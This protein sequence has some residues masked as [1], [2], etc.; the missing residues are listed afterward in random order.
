MRHVG[1]FKH[2]EKGMRERRWW[3]A[4]DCY[5]MCIDASVKRAPHLVADDRVDVLSKEVIIKLTACPVDNDS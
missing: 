5:N 1:R 3:V 2:S 4:D